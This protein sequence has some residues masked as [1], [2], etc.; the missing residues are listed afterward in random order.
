MASEFTFRPAVE[1]D[2]PFMETLSAASG[3]KIV[4]GGG[5]FV[6]RA[7]GEWFQQDPRLHFNQ[8]MFDGESK[9]APLTDLHTRWTQT[10]QYASVTPRS[11]TYLG[12]GLI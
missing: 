12:P 7:W 4:P 9:P 10:Q 6:L 3:Q 8:W 1:A 2:L 5:D 11:Y